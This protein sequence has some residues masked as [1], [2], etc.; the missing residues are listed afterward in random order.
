MRQAIVL[1]SKP[2]WT[3][4]GNPDHWPI[5]MK[6]NQGKS[7]LTYFADI[8]LSEQV[9]SGGGAG[10]G[11]M[12]MYNYLSTHRRRAG[13]HQCAVQ[14]NTTAAGYSP[15]EAGSVSPFRRISVSVFPISNTPVP[16]ALWLIA[17]TV[18]F[19]DGTDIYLVRQLVNQRIRRSRLPAGIIPQGY[20][21]RP[22]RNFMWTV[23]AEPDA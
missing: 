4:L 6:N 11:G 18:I 22:G 16:F 8:D 10:N 14:I 20:L 7:C 12:G 2:I 9:C 19:K 15:L 23:N 17:V 21:H 13:Y 5:I 1:P 3:R